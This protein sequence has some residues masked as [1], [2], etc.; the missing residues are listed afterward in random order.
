MGRLFV[1]ATPIGNLEDISARAIEVLK[2]VDLIA[3]E[4]TRHTKKLLT[5]LGISTPLKAYHAHNE[6]QQSEGL[7]ELLHHQDVA[8]VSDAGTPL[9]SDPGALL[10]EMA[11]AANITVIPIPGCCAAIAALSAA[12]LPAKGFCFEGFLPAKKQGKRELLNRL[13]HE[14]R[15]LIF[16]EAPHRILDTMTV[17]RET[18]G[19]QRC[20]LIAREITKRFETIQKGTLKELCAWIENDPN[21]QKGEFVIVVEGANL[22]Q[23]TEVSVEVREVLASLCHAMPARKACELLAKI[24]PFKKN[25]LYQEWLNTQD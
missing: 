5:H 6:K 14:T 19:E 7:I 4:D 11:H 22:V 24:T 2:S 8:L 16:Y 10:I 17:L 23:A 13:S 15:H 12:G 21:Q 25:Q 18:F 9:V 3:A 20:V 1:V